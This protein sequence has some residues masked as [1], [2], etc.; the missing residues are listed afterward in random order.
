MNAEHAPE[1]S[2]DVERFSADLAKR[3][4][5]LLMEGAYRIDA[6]HA[7][8]IEENYPPGWTMQHWLYSGPN[9]LVMET[10]IERGGHV[11][12]MLRFPNGEP[13]WRATLR[14]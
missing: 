4:A 5:D 6:E 9:A 12:L 13:V 14:P 11:A 3:V 8:L 1:N 7:R 2:A 10:R